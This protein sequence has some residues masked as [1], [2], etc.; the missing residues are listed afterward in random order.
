V[1][2]AGL[3]GFAV[4]ETKGSIG[5]LFHGIDSDG[6]VCGVDTGVE[7][8]PLLFWCMSAQVPTGAS[9][10]ALSLGRR[11][12]VES[13]P[14]GMGDTVQDCVSS[15]GTATPDGYPTKVLVGR[16]CMPDLDRYRD[17]AREAISSQLGGFD[18]RAAEMISS[19]PS[20]WPALI[21]AL[22]LAVAL[23][24]VHL[25]L[26]RCCAEV[27]IWISI[28][29]S[30]LGLGALGAYLWLSASSETVESRLPEDLQLSK[31]ASLSADE[32][33]CYKIASIVCWVLSIVALCMACCL[34]SSIDAA[35]ACVEVA[36]E[37]IFEMPTLLMAPAIKAI[38]KGLLS[39]GLLYGFLLLWSVGDTSGYDTPLSTAFNA[40]ANL[41]NTSAADAPHITHTQLQNIML[42]FYMFVAFWIL[43][44]VNALYQFV[45]AYT[46][47]TYYYAPYEEEDD[48][49]IDE[50]DVEG[51]CTALEGFHVG[52]V[53][54][55]GSLAFG[56]ALIAILQTIQ[57]VI[58]Y[59]EL[60]N[61]EAGDNKVVACVLCICSCCV[62]CL[63][64]IVGFIN[65]NAYIDMAITSNGFCTAARRA[66]QM[67]IELGGAMAI[68]NGATYVFAFFGTVFITVACTAATYA[69]AGFPPF[70]DQSSAFYVESPLSAALVG[71]VVSFL[72]ALSF[73]DVFDM[74]S[75][76]L[77]YCYGVDIQSGKED[78]TAPHALQELVHN[79]SDHHEEDGHGPG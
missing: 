78:H 14:G 72:V 13:C 38:S 76:T 42:I 21:G 56:A 74:A 75:D 36:C 11:V 59:S 45:V 31:S 28:A 33:H 27:F 2:F 3:Y 61:K 6:L 39:V 7:E 8:K 62:K 54:H 15:N 50:K 41:L 19:I 22:V 69:A 34:R 44:F 46:V 43:A 10:T 12:C 63:K 77:L 79:H 32:E 47:A 52:V 55:A 23:G 9:V 66:L 20:A 16:Y 40:T 18:E 65:R 57:K 70:T 53:Y 26:L 30:V 49:F 35:A 51:C 68:L 60:K 37:A 5:R 24:Y 4:K 1:A 48:H 64:D 29:L 58:E 73:M 67:V 25:F 17:A 71:A